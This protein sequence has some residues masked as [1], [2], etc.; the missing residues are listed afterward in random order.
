M[1][2]ITIIAL[3]FQDD[4]ELFRMVKKKVRKKFQ[5]DRKRTTPHAAARI[6]GQRP[7]MTKSCESKIYDICEIVDLSLSLDLTLSTPLFLI[8]F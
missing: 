7:N 3:R 6:Y 5:D 8:R 4:L 1:S 2:A